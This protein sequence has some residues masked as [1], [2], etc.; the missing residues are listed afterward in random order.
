MNKLIVGVGLLSAI[1]LQAKDKQKQYNILCVTCEDISQFVGCFGDK[2][3]KTPN[4]DAFANE[5]IR[6]SRMYTTVGV[7][8]P[9]RSALITGMYPSS[10]G[11][12]NMRSYVLPNERKGKTMPMYEVVLP[13]GVKCFTEYLRADGYYCTNNVKNDYQFAPP[14]TAWDENNVKAHWKNRPAGMPFYSVFNLEVSHESRI[15][16]R[17]NESLTTKPNE[18]VLPPY[19]PEDAIV[20]RDMAIMYSNITEMDRQFGEKIKELKDAGLYENTIIIWYSD[21]GGP[22]PNMKRSI[23]ERGTLVPFMIRFPD[24][25]RAGEKDSRLCMFPDIPATILSIAGIKP[26]A[27]MQGKPFLGKYTDKPRQYVYGAR[28]RM[29]EQVDKQGAIRD[30]RFRYVQNYMPEK[31]GYM[32][33]AYRLQIPMMRRLLDLYQKDS[34]ND[35]QKRWFEA[36]RTKE[37]FFDVENDPHELN[38]LIDNLAYAKDVAR[39]KKEYNNWLKKYNQN[40][41]R[42][43]KENINSFM[44]NGI[45]LKAAKPDIKFSGNKV[46]LSASCQGVSF[47]YQLNGAAFKD[48][49]KWYLYS[50]PFTVTSGTIIS[51]KAVRAGYIDSEVVQSTSL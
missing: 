41:F 30:K 25:Y 8:A 39:L 2:V 3:A 42:T 29:D 12:N 48:T 27:T 9:S 11:A 18:V 26:P 51:V 47:A 31:A 21:N 35:A 19:Y 6:F 24:G 1:S 15:W 33:V 4:L 46:S 28:D 32:P 13:E 43:E 49:E 20:R 38:N 45:Q 23:Y 44:P 37:E 34:L 5:A 17:A 22:L 14:L 10:I 50:K 36:P 40:W 16:M 7:S